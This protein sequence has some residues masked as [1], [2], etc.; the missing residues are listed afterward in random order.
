MSLNFDKVGRTLARIECGKMNNKIVSVYT[1]G[2]DNDMI[3]KQFNNIKLTGESK[4]QQIP[5]PD[6]ERQI[7]YITGAS[8]SGKSTYAAKYIKEYKKIFKNNPVYVF[9]ALK[10]D[11]SLDVIKPKR[12]IIDDSLYTNPLNVEDFESSIVIFDDIDVIS[13]KKQRE[14]VYNILNQILETGRHFHISCI[15]TNHLSTAGKDTKRVLNECHSVVYFPFSGSG[16]GLKRLLVDYLGLD[17]KDIIKAKKC[18]SRWVCIFK[19]YPQI[20]M[21]ER[22]LWMPATD[23]D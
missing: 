4:F 5:D 19:N 18:K 13:D 7:L 3:K 17:K 6:T 8:G 14:A 15:I 10:D 12:I 21:C 20:I 1:E 11:E 16:V 23:D 9:S 22:D 2:D